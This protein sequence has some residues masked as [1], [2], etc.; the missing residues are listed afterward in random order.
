MVVIQLVVVIV[1][2]AFFLKQVLSFGRRPKGYPPG[3]PTIPILGNLHQL[4]VEGMHLRFH[5]W[6]QNCETTVFLTQRYVKI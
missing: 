6:A 5:E 1:I 3:P 4:S 2:L